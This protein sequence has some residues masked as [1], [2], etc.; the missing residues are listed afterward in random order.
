MHAVVTIQARLQLPRPGAVVRS[1][2]IATFPLAAA[3]ALPRADEDACPEV[4]VGEVDD[5]AAGPRCVH[6]ESVLAACLLS[7]VSM[8]I[9]TVVIRASP[10]PFG[11]LPEVDVSGLRGG[12]LSSTA[13]ECSDWIFGRRE[14]S[15]IGSPSVMF[16]IAAPPLPSPAAR[17]NPM[18]VGISTT[19]F[20]PMMP[21]IRWRRIMFTMK[22]GCARTTFFGMRP[23]GRSSIQRMIVADITFIRFGGRDLSLA[24]AM[25]PL[26]EYKDARPDSVNE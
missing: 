22:C 21:S 20:P 6:G 26:H 16:T 13:G 23:S 1:R 19:R 12:V 4:D 8:V 2:S 9:A 3:A 10:L 18:T 7:A 11:A 17:P 14:P 15:T 5:A 25:T 24:C